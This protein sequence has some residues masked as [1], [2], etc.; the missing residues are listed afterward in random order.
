MDFIDYNKLITQD[1]PLF[2]AE[3]VKN[4]IEDGED[5]RQI[6][7]SLGFED[8]RIMAYFSTTNNI[9]QRDVIKTSII[10]V[11]NGIYNIYSRC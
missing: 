4:R 2:K 11:K 7:K 8:H 5:S 10:L 6:A 9:S 3:Q 1:K